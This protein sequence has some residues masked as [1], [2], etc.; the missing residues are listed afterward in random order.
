MN[1]TKQR[2]TPLLGRT[3]VTA[4]V[5]NEGPTPSRHTIQDSLAKE[6]K[7][8]RENIIIKHIFPRFGS[9][10]VKVIA[11]IYKDPQKL[12][13]LE[14]EYLLKKH[15]RPEEETPAQEEQAQAPAAESVEEKATEEQPAEEAETQEQKGD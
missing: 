10:A 14:H 15:E 9:Q 5:E 12:K 13:K 7:V 3:R 11:H 4:L 1:I 6:L 8:S 2:E